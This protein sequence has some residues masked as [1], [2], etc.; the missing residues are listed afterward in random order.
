MLFFIGNEELDTTVKQIRR[1]IRASMNGVVA[2]AMRDHGIVY[3]KNF[4]VSIL[5]LKEISKQYKPNHDLAQRLWALDIRETMILATWLQPIDKFTPQLADQW[6]RSLNQPELAEQLCMNLLPKLPF[7]DKLVLDWI[8]RPE[9]WYQITGFMLTA[10]IWEKLSDEQTNRLIERALELST[11][12]EFLLYK[13]IAIALARISRK[14]KE[15]AD[16][17]LQ[18]INHFEH[19]EAVSENYIFQEVYNEASFLDFL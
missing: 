8:N 3:K 12:D 2:D 16:F 15:R 13:S 11:T 6:L 19:S 5:R 17:I 18:K 14:G 1:K 9:L 7:S 4:G 10:R